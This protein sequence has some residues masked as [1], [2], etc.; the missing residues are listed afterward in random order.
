MEQGRLKRFQDDLCACLLVAFQL[1]RHLL[2]FLRRV[3][4][5]GTAAG[6]NAFL[7]S[8]SGCRKRVL[9]TKL[10]LLHLGLCRRTHADHSYAARQF[11]KTL[12][13]F[14]L[15]EIG[16]RLLDLLLNLVDSRLNL[17]LFT[18]TVHDNGVLFLHLNGLRTTELVEGCVLKLQ[19]KFGADYLTT[20]QD[21]DILQ[22]SLSSVAVAGR[23]HSNHIEG[24]TQFV[25]NQGCERLTLHVLSDDE[26][27]R[28]GL[29][30][31]L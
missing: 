1:L 27:L 15:I 2:H 26:E 11:R 12:L 4:I 6:N 7:H 19:T 8:R 21:S 18:L 22:H 16:S 25:H 31:L 20:C 10:R 14:L 29:Y 3:H 5:R 28:A 17:F 24:A 23:F 30:D 9:Q 13:Q